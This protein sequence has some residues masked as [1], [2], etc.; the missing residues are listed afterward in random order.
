MAEEASF[1]IFS[2]VCI[3]PLLTSVAAWPIVV[4][5]LILPF[6]MPRTKTYTATAIRK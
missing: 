5:A 6:N 4:P 3:L 1:F 2:R